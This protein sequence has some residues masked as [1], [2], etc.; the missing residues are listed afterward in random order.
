MPTLLI[1]INQTLSTS[2]DILVTTESLNSDREHIWVWD[3]Y[4][5]FI[6]NKMNNAQKANELINS[7]S[8]WAKDFCQ[9][10][11]QTFD[12]LEQKDLLRISKEMNIVPVLQEYDM[13]ILLEIT[14]KPDHWPD[15]QIQIPEQTSTETL[16]DSV[17]ALAQFY[18]T[19]NSNFYRELPLHIVAMRKF[20]ETESSF[21]DTNSIQQAPAYAFDTATKFYQG[22]RE[23]A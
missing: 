6:L 21:S 17:L 20:Y 9:Y 10:I 16:R 23:P 5:S 7:L 11:T 1:G 22:L 4:F 8:E 14:E 12:S 3:H 13:S 19:N 18:L 15:I 2:N